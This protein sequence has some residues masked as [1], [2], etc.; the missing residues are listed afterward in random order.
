MRLSFSNQCNSVKS[1]GDRRSS[2]FLSS[3]A[4][5]GVAALLWLNPVRAQEH[6]P[7]TAA[8]A[9]GTAAGQEA[10]AAAPHGE[11]GGATTPGATAPAAGGEHSAPAGESHAAPAADGHGAASDGH[12]AAGSSEAHG[13]AHGEGHKE[14]GISIHLPTWITGLLNV[15]YHAGPAS[16]S[17]SGVK[18]VDDPKS[19]IGKTVS[20][21]YKD[22]HGHG[23]GVD[24]KATIAS[25]GGAKS[26]DGV[27]TVQTDADGQ[28]I[29]L[30]NPEV[31]YELQS[32]FPEALII[33]LM[34]MIGI[35]LVAAALSKN[36][37]RIPSRKQAFA[38]VIYTALD[39][40]VAGLIPHNH[41]KY[42]PLVG[43]AFIY[44]LVMNLAG[45][46]PGWYSPTANI[47]VTAGMALVVVVYTQIEGIKAHGFGGYLKHFIGE[48]WWLGPLNFPIHAIGELAKILSLSI[49][50]FGN[51]FGED[52]VILILIGLAGMFT[53]GFFPAQAPM[54]L[55]AMFTSF[56]QA[57][58]FSILTC[59]YIVLMT[60]HEEGHEEHHDDH[61]HDHGHGHGHAHAH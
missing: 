22:P 45:L 4:F 61:G 13:G 43:A 25:I 29:T 10:P 37:T 36:P 49:R 59:V 34:T 12:A 57:M 20:F 38:E 35:L 41:Q 11:A 21:K 46:I 2:N 51:I 16:V 9:A 40:F 6:S 17:A 18:G 15:V 55:L 56:V 32:M 42:V 31:K 3:L 53:G 44:I 8:P 60:S 5:I 48:P 54:Y 27:M 1:A 30:I 28:S 50:L 19:L 14:E 58:V 7:S 33:S 39:S 24:V 23:D 52:V 47:N 26:T